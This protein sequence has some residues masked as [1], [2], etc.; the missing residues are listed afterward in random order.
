MGSSSQPSKIMV[1]GEQANCR[2]LSEYLHDRGCNVVGVRD[3]ASAVSQLESLGPDLVFVAEGV[4]GSALMRLLARAKRGPRPAHVVLLAPGEDIARALKA[5]RLGI[6]SGSAEGAGLATE[7]FQIESPTVSHAAQ[8]D[9]F[10]D[11]VG[12]SAAI[13][14]VKTVI[15]EVAGSELTVLIVG[16]TGSGKGVAA[17]AVHELSG[18]A[19]MPFVKVNCAALPETL[20]ESELF[21]HEKGAFTGAHASKPGRFEFANGGSIFLDEISEMSPLLQAKLLQVLEEKRFMRV[22]GRSEIAVDVRIIAATNKNMADAMEAGQF[23]SDLYYRLNEVSVHMPALRERPE[24]IPLLARHLAVR[25]AEQYHRTC[26]G[27]PHD[28]QIRL[29]DYDWPGNVRELANVVKRAVVSG[30]DN[31]ALL[32][33]LGVRAQRGTHSSAG[34]RETPPNLRD[35]ARRA[36]LAA[37][38]EVIL[39]TL[40]Q[41]KWNRAEAARLL[42]VA[43]KTLLNKMKDCDIR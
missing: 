38:R 18:R 36:A 40:E 26:P 6:G 28:L 20:L 16:E 35:V 17:K 11:L 30:V 24:D 23:R 1:V 4:T 9:E 15:R 25:F 43:Y 42:G 37:E 2:R 8:P 3:G 5:L 19:S 10:P 33:G 14:R 22:G 29:M 12:T 39:A 32:G 21:G 13:H 41:T 27:L 31:V 7:F 34:K